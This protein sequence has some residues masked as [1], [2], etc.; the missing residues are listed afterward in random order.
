MAESTK[1]NLEQE[2]GKTITVSHSKCVR[3]N[4]GFEN[5]LKEEPEGRGFMLLPLLTPQMGMWEIVLYVC[6]KNLLCDYLL[7]LVVQIC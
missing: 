5:V 7:A 2:G 1:C 3:K 4:A 6:T